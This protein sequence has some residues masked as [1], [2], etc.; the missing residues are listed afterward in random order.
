[1]VG[2]IIV[3]YKNWQETIECVESIIATTYINYLIFIID[4]N[5]P[6]NS[7]KQ[8]SQYCSQ[9]QNIYLVAL[10]ENK[11]YA[12]G[13]NIGIIKAIELGCTNIIISNPDIIFYDKAIDR[14]VEKL[15][16]SKKLG[17]VGPKVL[18][19]NLSIQKYARKPLTFKRYISIKRPFLFIMFK[20]RRE[21]LNEQYDYS[22]NFLFQG[23]VSGCCFAIKS[24][25]IKKIGGFDN[26]T[27][28][29]GEEDIIGIKLDRLGQKTCICVDSKV[30]HKRSSAIDKDSSAFIDYHRYISAYYTLVKYVKINRFERIIVSIINIGGFMLKSIFDSDY[31]VKLSSLV[32]YYRNIR[33]FN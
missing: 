15:E 4:N 33:I 16:S 6:N 10:K 24:E 14:L 7:V 13:N 31:I 18:D 5:S 22:K 30:M 19:E 3:N 28:L 9:K 27:F 2:I 26:I 23:M 25:T 11:G 12:M 29:Y 1:V 32:K 21:Y 8:L 20:T 17:V